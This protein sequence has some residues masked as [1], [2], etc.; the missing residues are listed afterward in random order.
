MHKKAPSLKPDKKLAA[1]C[2]L[3]CP[4]C[5]VYIAT[6]DDPEELE[7]LSERFGYTVEETK[8]FGCGSEK[9]LAYCT[10]N[11]KIYSCAEK[12]GIDF[13]IECEE[14]PCEELKRFQAEAPHRIE[15]F[16]MQERIKEVG[17]EKWFEEMINHYSCAKCKTINSAYNIA[18]R[19]CGHEPSCEYVRLHKEQIK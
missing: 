1:V 7:R 17:L 19:N 4:S 9:R 15:L 2:G 18:C 3:F 8:C 11:C 5:S 6:Q 10:D 16:Q 13:C 14:Y 12:K